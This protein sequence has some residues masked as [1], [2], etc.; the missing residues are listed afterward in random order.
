MGFVRQ[1]KSSIH[2]LWKH[3]DVEEAKADLSTGSSH[4]LSVEARRV[5]R[6]TY[7]S[8]MMQ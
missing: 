8:S 3:T 6:T 7:L 1:I 5:P 4:C 2:R